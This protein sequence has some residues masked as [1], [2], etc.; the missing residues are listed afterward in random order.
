MLHCFSVLPWNTPWVIEKKGRG[1]KNWTCQNKALKLQSSPP[2]NQRRSPTKCQTMRP[3][4]LNWTLKTK[5]KVVTVSLMC[6]RSQL[7]LERTLQQTPKQ[8][9]PTWSRRMISKIFLNVP[10]ASGF[11]GALQY[12]RCVVL[13]LGYTVKYW[14]YSPFSVPGATSCVQSVAQTWPRVRSAETPWATSG[15][16]FQ[17]RCWRSFP[18]SVNTRI[19]VVRSDFN[20]LRSSVKKHS[21][22]S[23]A[24]VQCRN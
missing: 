3:L 20:Q 1:K 11:P 15:P 19:K 2:L 8:T 14:G 5:R 4:N 24:T 6:H 13:D 17:R 7:P 21:P 16:S 18:V 22:L 9:W 10:S 12:I 23:P